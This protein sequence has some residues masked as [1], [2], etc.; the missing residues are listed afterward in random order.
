MD[1]ATSFHERVIFRTDLC[2]HTNEGLQHP[3]YLRQFALETIH[4]IP[5]HALQIYT[6]GSMGAG[7]ISGSGIFIFKGTGIKICIKNPDFCSVFRSELI[8]I[9][10][11]VKFCIADNVNLDVWILSDSRSSIQHL[12][13]WWRYGD[14]TTV[15]I[16]KLL[17][18]L[19]HDIRIFFQWVPSHVNVFGNEIADGLAREGSH[20]HTAGDDLS[21]K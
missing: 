19:S 7:A 9:E 11:A 18:G 15:N 16:V 13:E 6:D 17:N 3:E 21:Q 12:S 5:N 2:S 10:E 1:V 4:K 8:A 20:R 14:R